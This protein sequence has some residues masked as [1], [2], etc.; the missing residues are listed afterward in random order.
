M[1]YKDPDKQRAFQR[2]RVAARRRAYLR[3]KVC[4]DC[5]ERD[6]AVLEFDHIDPT[7][8]DS[9]RIWSWATARLEAELAKC[10][11]RCR[12]CHQERHAR[13]AFRHGI[14]AYQKHGCRCEI[15]REAKRESNRR[16]AERRQRES[17]ARPRL[18]RPAHNHSAMAPSVLEG[19]ALVELGA[20]S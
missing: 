10:E 3:G 7:E 6:P 20:E 14:G 12:P 4:V 11:V 13:L 17:N 19:Y 9:H 1:P 2:V 8:K 16:Y 18:C 15:C 5:G